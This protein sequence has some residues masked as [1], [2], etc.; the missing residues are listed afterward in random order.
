MPNKNLTI[1]FI[2]FLLFVIVGAVIVWIISKVFAA[3]EPIIFPT[4]KKDTFE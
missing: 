4:N 1:V 2:A 3:R